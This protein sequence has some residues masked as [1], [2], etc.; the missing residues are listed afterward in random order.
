[1][2]EPVKN[3]DFLVSVPIREFNQREVSDGSTVRAQDLDGDGLVSAWS[4]VEDT[5]VKK[6]DGYTSG[7]RPD[8]LL[9][10]MCYKRAPR[11]TQF[12]ITPEARKRLE[13]YGASITTTQTNG[14]Q[15][16]SIAFPEGTEVAS[17][18]GEFSQDLKGCV[19]NR[20]V[21]IVE[22]GKD[23]KTVI[24]KGVD[25]KGVFESTLNLQTRVSTEQ[26]K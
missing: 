24:L 25:A 10:K 26:R 15:Y 8:D 19:Y 3:K 2:A 13:G 14:H 12:N 18:G 21:V 16:Q 1:M 5:A 7:S 22:A 23:P 20:G 4:E 17:Y 9:A 11:P 6:G